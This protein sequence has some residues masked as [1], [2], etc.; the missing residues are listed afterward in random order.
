MKHRNR[1]Q[2]GNL[3]TLP[4]LTACDVWSGNSNMDLTKILPKFNLA[5]VVI[6][7]A[8]INLYLQLN[9]DISECNRVL[10]SK[11][12]SLYLRRKINQRRFSEHNIFNRWSTLRLLRESVNVANPDKKSMPSSVVDLDTDL[13]Q[14]YLI[15][16]GLSEVESIDYGSESTDEQREETLIELMPAFE[17]A[18]Y[19]SPWNLIQKSLVRSER[20]LARLQQPLSEFDANETFLNATRLTLQDYQHLIFGVYTRYSKFSPEDILK[21]TEFFINTKPSP[22]LMPLYDKLLQHTCISIDELAHKAKEMSSLPNEFSLWRKYP[23][24][25]ISENQ[26]MCVDIGF[27]MDKLETGVFWIIRD[28]LDKEQKGKETNIFDMRGPVFEDYVASIIKR[29]TNLQ[30]LSRKETCIPDPRYIQKEDNQ[31]T[32]IMVCSREVLILIECKAHI[33]S[34]KAKFSGDFSELHN[35]I[36][37]K[38]IA[39]NGKNQLWNAIRNLGHVDAMK[40]REVNGL[41]MSR[42]RQIF[43]VLVLSDRIFS[44]KFMNRFFDMEFQPF[45]DLDE[46]K[47]DLEIMPLTVLTIDNLEDLEPYLHDTPLH[48]HLEKWV[49]TFRDNKSYP[50]SQYLLSLGHIPENAYMEQQTQRI[51]NDIREYFSSHGLN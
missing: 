28:E 41:D 11:F 10:K 50:F 47:K 33:L 29:G 17:Y 36:I 35:A 44:L 3:V 2:I 26:I 15:A 40:R 14:C 19:S 8:R 30:P 16:N 39:P 27:L 46:L 23:L 43:P 21:G 22:T 1:M 18:I 12:C 51:D 24:V 7:L 6:T 38:I 5:D 20:L 48:V 9:E 4:T 32:D 42:I 34:S 45:V 31:C 37:S 13:G 49:R 25:K